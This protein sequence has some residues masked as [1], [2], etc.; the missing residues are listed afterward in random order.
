MC[1]TKEQTKAGA[2]APDFKSFLRFLTS[3][4]GF[5]GLLR[6]CSSDDD[7]NSKKGA[8]VR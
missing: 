3:D 4:D 5:N 2:A 6:F 1:K 7:F 8:R